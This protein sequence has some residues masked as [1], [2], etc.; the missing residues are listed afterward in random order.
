MDA[1]DVGAM[2]QLCLS[3]GLIGFACGYMY[4]RT[5][6]DRY[7]ESLFTRRDE[8]FDY[9]WKNNL[10]FDLPAYRLMRTFLNGAIRVAGEASPLAFVV[11]M[12]TVRRQG[13]GPADRLFTAIA[14][15]ED[16][17]TREHFE[18]TLDDVVREWFAFLGVIGALF[19]LASKF[20]RFRSQVRPKANRW[21]DELVEIG[22]QDSRVGLGYGSR[23]AHR[24]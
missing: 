8:L 1:Q 4:T 16:A 13:P 2:V 18:Q 6:V 7:R 21:M 3:L 22:G 20:D 14:A 23:F 17:S 11:L 5:R 24:R 9:M 19:E 12:F 15:I 10:S